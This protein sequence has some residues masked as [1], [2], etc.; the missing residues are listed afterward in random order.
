MKKIFFRLSSL[1]IV[2]LFACNNDS[3]GDT[4]GADKDPLKAEADSLREEVMNGHNIAM[5][6]SMRIPDL[7]KV[8][9]RLLDSIAKLPVKAQKATAPYKA[10]LD[11]LFKNLDYAEMVMDKWMNEYNDTLFQNNLEQRIK[12]LAEEKMK[13]EVVKEKVLGSLAKADSLLKAKL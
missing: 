8:T 7:K 3:G 9:T 2:I 1:L 12:Y 11:S 5:P 4:T 10:K 6:K 13:V